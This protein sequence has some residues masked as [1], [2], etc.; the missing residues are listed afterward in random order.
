MKPRAQLLFFVGLFLM[1]PLGGMEPA[2]HTEKKE[3][4]DEQLHKILKKKPNASKIMQPLLNLA[5]RYM[6][7]KRYNHADAAVWARNH[8]ALLA[9]NTDDGFLVADVSNLLANIKN[10]D[11]PNEHTL[12]FVTTAQV[13]DV[14]AVISLQKKLNKVTWSPD[15]KCIAGVESDF[16]TIHMLTL[17]QDDKTSDQASQVVPKTLR[18][19]KE[20]NTLLWSPDAHFLITATQDNF[21]CFWNRAAAT[22]QHTID[23]KDFDKQFELPQSALSKLLKRTRPKTCSVRAITASPDGNYLAT[24]EYGNFLIK[25]WDIRFLNDTHKHP[26][27]D[28]VI[29]EHMYVK[30]IAWSPDNKYLAA[31][32]NNDEKDTEP[33]MVSIYNIADPKNPTLNFK[34]NTD[35]VMRNCNIEWNTQGSVLSLID[36]NGCSWR[37]FHRDVMDWLQCNQANS[38]TEDQKIFLEKI[39]SKKQPFII[40]EG[41]PVNGAL[42]DGLPAKLQDALIRNG[43]VVVEIGDHTFR[44]PDASQSERVIY[45]GNGFR[46]DSLTQEE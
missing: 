15:N 34:W 23:V 45:A 3:T 5:A 38:I 17:P 7:I 42:F 32:L 8:S 11:W 24:T 18:T 36:S 14:P 35:F 22:M 27:L 19:A 13:P 9:Y 43:K 46:P 28:A 12:S 25:I 20:I 30:A 2:L 6:C 1:H 16:K 31:H 41:G 33:C 21:I 44:K 26:E 37:L 39:L 40:F 29:A 10:A 4:F